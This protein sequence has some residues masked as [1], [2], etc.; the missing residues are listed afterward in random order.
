MLILFAC[1]RK[2]RLVVVSVLVV[3]EL[4]FSVNREPVGMNIQR[5]HKYANH[6]TLIVKILCFL[7]LLDN[8]NLAVSRSYNKFL[9]V[10]IKVTN[11]TAVEVERHKPGGTKD[12]Y[13]GPER[14]LVV[15]KEP[16][17]KSYNTESD[18]T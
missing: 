9:R 10:A 15:N 3:Y 11:R 12:Y 8:Y 4:D 14:N 7:S 16:K 17:Y 2:P 13:E 5:T 6:E 1:F 18:K